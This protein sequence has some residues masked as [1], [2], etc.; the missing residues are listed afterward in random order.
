MLNLIMA[1]WVPFHAS[2]TLAQEPEKPADMTYQEGLEKAERVAEEVKEPEEMIPALTGFDVNELGFMKA[3]RIQ[4]GAW[5]DQGVN[6]NP[7]NPR[8]KFNGPVTFDDVANNYQL[9]QFNLYIERPTDKEGNHYDLGF[10]GEVILGTDA[11]FIQATGL[12]ISAEKQIFLEDDG[13]PY[14]GVAAPQL[15]IEG[16]APWGR[17]LTLK[18]GHF[19]TPIGYEVVPANGNFFYSHAYTFQYG[20][21]FTHTGALLSYPITDNLTL[22]A[23]AVN[24]WDNWN[25][26]PGRF[27]GIGAINWVSADEKTSLALS[28]ISGPDKVSDQNLSLYSLVLIHKFL[29]KFTGVIQHDNGFLEDGAPDGS[30]AQWYGINSYL[31]Y[32]VSDKLATGVRFEWFRD[33][34]GVRVA[35]IM[36]V[37]GVR[38]PCCPGVAANYYEITGGVNWKPKPWLRI[39][40]ELRFDWSTEP[41]FDNN[42]DQTQFLFAVDAV[43]TF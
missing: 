34:D 11:R 24:G 8:P 21:P 6:W 3:W 7:Q 9:N 33:D 23:G 10:R 19:Y 4:T 29:E 38:N 20:E 13:P 1:G 30:T 14:Y 25:F 39:R 36:T 37:S 2:V 43:V 41:V 42:T 12:E 40:P 5:L 32:D 26:N 18:G 22:T 28:G 27:S 16:F 15:Y 17:G 35:S 31:F